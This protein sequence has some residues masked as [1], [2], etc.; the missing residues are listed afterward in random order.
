M[1]LARAAH[2]LAEGGTSLRPGHPPDDALLALLAHVAAAD[3]E[4]RDDEL[5]M[6]AAT[7]PTWNP[8]E[9][10]AF[11]LRVA[12]GPAELDRLAAAFATDDERWTALRFVS[13]MAAKDAVVSPDELDLLQRLAAALGLP[14]GAAARA[15]RELLAGPPPERRHPSALLQLVLGYAWDAADVMPGPASSADLLDRVPADALPVARVGVDR[16]EV[17]GLYAEGM[18]ARF[19]EGP[20]WLRW[21]DVIGWSAGQGLGAALCVHTE[22]GRHWTLIDQRLGGLRFV[23]DRLF[24]SPDPIDATPPEILASEAD[25]D[26]WD[27]AP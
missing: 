3:G 2:L 22:D 25:Q 18:V 11:V 1:S 26:T 20:A 13:R 17:I 14:E 27:E 12:G 6:L 9:V 21:Q 19:A 24:R 5:E 16:A 15:C 23:L 8:A 4:V 7:L 10:E